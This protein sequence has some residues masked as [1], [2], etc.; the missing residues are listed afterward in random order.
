M[1][2]GD[3]LNYEILEIGEFK[4]LMGN[5]LLAILVAGVSYLIILVM[6][7]AILQPRFLI[8]KIDS[9]RRNSIF[10]ILKYFIWVI[11]IVVMLEVIGVEVTVILVGSTALLVGLGLGLQHIF[12][13]L[14]SGLFLLFE[15][16]IKIG[17]ILEADGVVGKVTEINLRSTELRTRDDVT[18]IIPNSKFVVEKVINWSHSYEHVRFS[19]SVGVAYG[20]NIE[21]VISCLEEAMEETYDIISQPTPYVWFTEFGESS[22]KFEMVF[23]TKDI[24]SIEHTKSEL[25]KIAYK[26]LQENDLVIPFPQRDIHIKG[27]ENFNPGARS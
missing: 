16:S 13:D 11:T 7:K 24:F 26:K 3:F 22:L 23:W 5:L 4:L 17:D 20:S 27:I 9:K 10:L 14:V 19:V 2:W 12:T 21:K 15:G 6:R 8:D 18:I 1:E 25:R